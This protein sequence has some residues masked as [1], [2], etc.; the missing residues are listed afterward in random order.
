MTHPS[1]WPALSPS[2]GVWAVWAWGGGGLGEGFRTVA[3]VDS[4]F[5][6]PL[7]DLRMGG[8]I[9]LPTTDEVH[10]GGH[11]CGACTVVAIGILCH[12]GMLRPPS[13]AG[14]DRSSRFVSLRDCLPMITG[15][16]WY[17]NASSRGWRSS[18]V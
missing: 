7:F 11:H 8:V 12:D 18:S 3:S 10:K 9:M 2:V 6:L 16:S 1:H 14:S 15:S 13:H 17:R 4:G 5:P